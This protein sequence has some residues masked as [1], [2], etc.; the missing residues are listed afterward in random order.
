MLVAGLVIGGLSLFDPGGGAGVEPEKFCLFSHGPDGSAMR[1]LLQR[2]NPGNNRAIAE[3]L[4]GSYIRV[5]ARAASQLQNSDC[6]AA[7]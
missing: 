6:T 4:S 7:R 1:Q 5:V 3:Q 2:N